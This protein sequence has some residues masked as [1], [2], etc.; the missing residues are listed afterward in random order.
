MLPKPR[1][2]G[3]GLVLAAFACRALV[4]TGF[5]PATLA[6]GGPIILCP[7]GSAGAIVRF[8]AE[9]TAGENA[10]HAPH[11]HAPDSYE[12]WEYCPVGAS[13][14]AALEVASV[15]F[16]LPVLEHVLETIEPARIVERAV[17]GPY[18][19]RAPPIL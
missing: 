7:G 3:Y 14:G 11:E 10:H 13:L 6:S 2:L 8:L 19:A 16:V 18:R 5:M 9:R 4:P 17:A 15:D 1:Q 12:A